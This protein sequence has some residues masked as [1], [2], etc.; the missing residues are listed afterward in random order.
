MSERFYFQADNCSLGY[1]KKEVLSE[2][3]F[4][5]EPGEIVVLI[6]PNGAGKSTLLK[7]LTMQLPLLEGGI[8]LQGKDLRSFSPN[9]RAREYALFLT[10]QTKPAYMTCYEVVAMGRYPYT[11][12]MGGLSP[13]DKEIIQECLLAVDAVELANCSF[14][15]L[16]DGQRQRILLACCMAREP[17]IIFLDEPTS[18]LD[19]KYKLELFLLLKKLAQEKKVSVIMSVHEL[20]YA[21]KIADKVICVAR[22]GVERIGEPKEIFTPEMICKLFDIPEEMYKLI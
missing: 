16:S 7:S 19:I 18:F 5:V 22:G 3:S 14:L 10:G 20:E 9:Q 12:K 13:H 15:E 8:Y 6:G 4:G 17:R 2:V 21:E 1:G 11:G